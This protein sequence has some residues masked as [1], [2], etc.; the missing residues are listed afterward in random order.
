MKITTTAADAVLMVAGFC[1]C[2]MADDV[3]ISDGSGDLCDTK[4]CHV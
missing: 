2:F 3:F 1:L 4:R